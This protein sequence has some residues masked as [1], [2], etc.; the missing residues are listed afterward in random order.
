MFLQNSLLILI[1]CTL[2]TRISIKSCWHHRYN[3]KA[4]MLSYILRYRIM[5]YY[6]GEK[7]S[8]L[9]VIA[10]GLLELLSHKKVIALSKFE[11]L[12]LLKIIALVS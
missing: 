5:L 8:L 4:I 7:L 12:S 10:P 3:V 1:I 9:K 11:P 6:G 2:K